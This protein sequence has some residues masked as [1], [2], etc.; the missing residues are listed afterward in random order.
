MFAIEVGLC[1]IF[2]LINDQIAYTR[3]NSS[4]VQRQPRFYE[5]ALQLLLMDCVVKWIR[6]LFH[7]WKNK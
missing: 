6:M 5:T 2:Q 4:R 3:F 7:S 1:V